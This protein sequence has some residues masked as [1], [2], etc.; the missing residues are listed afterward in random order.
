MGMQLF[1]TTGD[2]FVKVGAHMRLQGSGA[3]CLAL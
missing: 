2:A 1:A 3:Q